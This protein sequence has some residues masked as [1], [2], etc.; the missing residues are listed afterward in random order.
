MSTH[1][2][3]G[4]QY[5]IKE[6]DNATGAVKHRRWCNSREEFEDRMKSFVRLPGKRYYMHE[7][8]VK[9]AH[10]ADTPGEEQDFEV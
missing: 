10:C 2:H 7:Q 1:P 4:K 5:A 9:C 6:V 8:D 3:H